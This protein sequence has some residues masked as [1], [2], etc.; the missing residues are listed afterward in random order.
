[1]NGSDIAGLILATV[2]GSIAVF[3]VVLFISI[4]GVW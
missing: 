4:Q 3:A 1:M 2:L